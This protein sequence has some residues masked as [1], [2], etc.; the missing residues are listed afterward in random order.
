MSD[1]AVDS[2]NSLGAGVSFRMTLEPWQ[3]FLLLIISIAACVIVGIYYLKSIPTKTIAIDVQNLDVYEKQ[4]LDSTVKS[5]GAVQFYQADLKEIYNA[6][7][8]LSWVD[9]VNVRRD[10]REGIV[11]S[12]ISKKA[13]ANF[14]SDRLVDAKGDVFV[15]ADS[16]KLTDKQLVTLYGDE[17]HADEVMRRMYQLNEWFAPLGLMTRDVILTPRQTWL[18]RFDNGLRLT[19]DNENTDQKLYAA[20]RILQNAALADKRNQIQAVDL[21]YKNGFA[22]V[23]K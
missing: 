9:S 2:K 7:N 14:G 11:V 20:S 23:W 13:V 5:L 12:V 3:G 21:R 22:I 15:P 8:A 18:I 10:W 4:S 1:A 19:V 6:V 17:A 16:H